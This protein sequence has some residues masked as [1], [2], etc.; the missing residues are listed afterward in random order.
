MPYAR[1]FPQLFMFLKKRI[2]SMNRHEMLRLHKTYDFFLQSIS[3]I[4]HIN[5]LILQFLN[6]YNKNNSIIDAEF[7]QKLGKEWICMSERVT[8]AKKDLS[9]LVDICLVSGLMQ[10]QCWWNM[11][12]SEMKVVYNMEELITVKR[13]V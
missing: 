13:K 5:E 4:F 8:S 9:W 6:V 2:F 3:Q 11:Q 1:F 10:F 7:S 12:F